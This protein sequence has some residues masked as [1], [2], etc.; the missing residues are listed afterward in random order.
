MHYRP[1]GS[2]TTSIAETTAGCVGHALTAYLSNRRAA[3]RT[4]GSYG[5]RTE[6]GADAARCGIKP[7]SLASAI[8]RHTEAKGSSGH[9]GEAKAVTSGL[10]LL[11]LR[12]GS[13]PQKP[14]P[15]AGSPRAGN[16]GGG[17]LRQDER[18]V[19]GPGRGRS[20]D[21]A[22]RALCEALG[23]EGAD[24]EPAVN[25]QTAPP[26]APTLYPGMDGSRSFLRGPQSDAFTPYGLHLRTRRSRPRRGSCGFQNGDAAGDRTS[27][28]EPNHAHGPAPGKARTP[29]TTAERRHFLVE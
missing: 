16:G 10:R 3:D 26:P 4:D 9:R 11:R 5:A 15:G 7:G 2:G 27:L 29:D 21:P 13:N 20:R 14:T 23:R 19:G 12:L 25:E 1:A 28:V 22:G 18:T 6:F 24:D 17:Q 8:G